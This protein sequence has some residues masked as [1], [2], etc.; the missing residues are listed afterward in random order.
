[1]FNLH[2]PVLG[3]SGEPIGSVAAILDTATLAQFLASAAEPGTVFRLLDAD[4]R[5]LISTDPRPSTD[6]VDVLRATALIPGLPVAL[7]AERPLHLAFAPFRVPRDR[8]VGT[9][10]LVVVAASLLGYG[11]AGFVAGR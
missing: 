2:A 5:V 3:R 4:R 8:A 10:F 11:F 9:L 7:V 6:G 1:V